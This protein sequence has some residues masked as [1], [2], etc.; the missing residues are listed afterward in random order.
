MRFAGNNYTGEHRNIKERAEKLCGLVDDDL[1]ERYIRFMTV[2]APTK[3][4]AKSSRENTMLYWRKGNYSSI[5]PALKQVLKTMNKEERNNNVIALPNWCYHFLPNCFITPQHNLVKEGKADRLIFDARL[6]GYLSESPYKDLEPQTDCGLAFGADFSPPVWE[7]CRRM[8]EQLSERLFEDD[9]L[10]IKHAQYLDKL[11]WG[12]KQGNPGRIVKAT[13]CPKHQGVLDKHGRPVNTPHNYF[14]DDGIAAEVYEREQIRRAIAA[15][16]EA[17]FLLLELLKMLT[18]EEIAPLIGK[19]NH[20]AQ[21]IRWMNHIMGHLYTSLMCALAKNKRYLITTNK[22]F[23]DLLKLKKHEP[24]T[25]EEEN[26]STFAQ[27]EMSKKVYRTKVK[28]I[29]LPTAKTELHL[30]RS[31]LSDPTIQKRAPISHLIDKTH[32]SDHDGDSSFDAMGG[33]SIRMK[34]W[35]YF[36]G[37]KEVREHT[38]RFIKNN[39]DGELIAI[40][41]MEYGT[42]QVGIALAYYYWCI[43]KEQERQGIEYLTVLLRAD[44]KSAEAWT[45]KGCKISM[46]GRALGR[47]QCARMMNNPVGLSSEY[48]NTKENKIPDEISRIESEAKLLPAISKLYQKYPSIGACRCFHPNPELISYIM[49]ALCSQQLINPLTIRELVQKNPGKIVGCSIAELPTS[50]TRASSAS[51]PKTQTLL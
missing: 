37:P 10:V 7:Q 4:N 32:D 29:L 45:R 6:K 47:L 31:A 13:P 43:L 48:I 30:I 12:P 18:I 1:L 50:L 16:I 11:Q 19:L 41:A 42:I 3:F 22:Q 17:I 33:I 44:N 51:N 27:S 23:R 38:L 5:P 21:T 20:M 26:L 25:K 9:T 14:V 2:G 49:A 15:D 28:H 34:M 36:E 39:K 24:E 46:A 8:A 40:N 35:W